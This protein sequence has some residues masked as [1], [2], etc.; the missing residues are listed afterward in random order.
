MELRRRQEDKT[1]TGMLNLYDEVHSHLNLYDEVT[2]LWPFNHT[3]DGC[4]K[5]VDIVHDGETVVAYLVDEIGAFDHIYLQK[6]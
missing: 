5:I 6:V 3:Y 4:Y 1:V 2:V